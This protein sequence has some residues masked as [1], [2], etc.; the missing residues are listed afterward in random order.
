MSSFSHT[1]RSHFNTVPHSFHI[2]YPLQDKC[3]NICFKWSN[4]F[5]AQTPASYGETVEAASDREQSKNAHRSHCCFTECWSIY[6]W[7]L[8]RYGEI[9]VT[10]KEQLKLSLFI[11]DKIAYLET[12]RE[13][14]VIINN[15]I[16]QESVNSRI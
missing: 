16:I 12:P 8:A 7:N 3:M 14:V 10:E 4:T 15:K 1:Q 2:K 11:D 6:L 13:L 5:L 9:I